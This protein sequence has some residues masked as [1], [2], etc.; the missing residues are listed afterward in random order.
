MNG[1]TTGKDVFIPIDWVIGG[2]AQVG[3]GWRMLM[4]CLAA[5]RSISLPSMSMA[6][7]KLGSARDRRLRA[8]PLAVQDAHRPVRGHRGAPRAHRR[9]D[10]PDGRACGA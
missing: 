9:H 4:E 7:G 1:P 5:G 10:L 6:A 3:K 8:H 2:A